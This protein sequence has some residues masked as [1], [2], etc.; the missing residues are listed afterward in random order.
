MA[1]GFRPDNNEKKDNKKDVQPKA[2]E[3]FLTLL[4]ENFSPD[5][6]DKFSELQ[7]LTTLQLA[8]KFEDMIDFSK[9]SLSHWL[10]DE[11]YQTT[12]FE[13]NLAWIMYTQKTN[14]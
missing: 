6:T 9:S 7:F 10:L 1:I 2:K 8:Y 14:T 11:G 5:Q 3:L 4:R 12:T 13:G